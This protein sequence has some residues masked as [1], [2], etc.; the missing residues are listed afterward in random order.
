[1]HHRSGPV[2][3]PRHRTIGTGRC[4]WS[5]APSNW[6]GEPAG[7]GARKHA[8]CVLGSVHQQTSLLHPKT[9]HLVFFILFHLSLFIVLCLGLCLMVLSLS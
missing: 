2:T 6:S 3:L 8:L 5:G 1:V 4:R 9:T 7:L